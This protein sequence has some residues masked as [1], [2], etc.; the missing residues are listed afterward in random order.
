MNEGDESKHKRGL[1]GSKEE[2]NRKRT[3][4]PE[5]NEGEHN[6]YKTKGNPVEERREAQRLNKPSES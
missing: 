4:T 3:G 2:S 6:T 5:A 1:I